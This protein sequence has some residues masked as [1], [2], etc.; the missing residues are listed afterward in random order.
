MTEDR[1]VD[2]EK[3]RRLDEAIDAAGAGWYL[4]R[5]PRD[6]YHRDLFEHPDGG[7]LYDELDCPN[8]SQVALIRQYRADGAPGPVWLRMLPVGPRADHLPA[9]FLV[10]T[11]AEVHDWF[12]ECWDLLIEDGWRIAGPVRVG[13][14]TTGPIRLVS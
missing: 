11:A 2:P 1:R 13:V 3:L 4:P 10:G 7:G 14:E 6:T 5:A 8:G 9:R 12:T